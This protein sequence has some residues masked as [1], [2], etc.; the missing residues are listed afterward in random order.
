MVVITSRIIIITRVGCR[1]RVRI[2]VRVRDISRVGLRAGD[3]HVFSAGRKGQQEGG[4][5]D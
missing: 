3:R 1:R 5:N 2:G 4:K